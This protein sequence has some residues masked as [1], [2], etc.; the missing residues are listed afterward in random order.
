MITFHLPASPNTPATNSVS[1]TTKAVPT[2]TPGLPNSSRRQ[3]LAGSGLAA[4]LAA[5]G[6][7]PSAIPLT[8]ADLAGHPDAALIRTAAEHAVN[9][10]A[11]NTSTNN[12][13]NEDDPLWHLLH[14]HERRA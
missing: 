14:A 7:A 5:I 6:L 10:A 13:E 2:T 8:G 12:V 11:F 4:G 9:I 3:L 1:T